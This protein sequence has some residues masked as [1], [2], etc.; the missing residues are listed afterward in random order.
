MRPLTFFKMRKLFYILMFVVTG[1]CLSCHRE[2]ATVAEETHEPQEDFEAA[3]V[4]LDAYIE[5]TAATRWDVAEDMPDEDCIKLQINYPGG[6][7]KQLFNDSNYR[8]YVAAERLGIEPMLKEK[9]VLPLKRPLERVKSN[10]LYYVSD[11]QHSYPYLVPESKALLNEIAQRFQ[12]TLG[13]RGGGPYRLKVTSLLRTEHTVSRLRRV[14]RASV[15]SSAHLFGTT[16]D[17]SFTN[18]PYSG[19]EPHRTQE[20]LKNLLA[21][22]LY[23]VREEGKCYVKYERKPGCFHITARPKD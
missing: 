3:L 7:L 14:N 23:Q 18:F 13:A 4:F 19:G 16:F 17:I 8:H 22:I 21:E 1:L 10:E 5:D 9:T 20:D 6:Y 2:A 11:L 15:D 12:D